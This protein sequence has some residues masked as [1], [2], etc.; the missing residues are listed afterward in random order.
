MDNRPEQ[1]KPDI[2]GEGSHSTNIEKAA[3]RQLASPACILLSGLPG[4]GKRRCFIAD[5]IRECD[6]AQ[7]NVL[8]FDPASRI[9][10]TPS[11]RDRDIFV[12][13][14][15]NANTIGDVIDWQERQRKHTAIPFLLILLCMDDAADFVTNVAL[16]TQLERARALGATVLISTRT[17]ASR[18]L[19]TLAKSTKYPNVGSMFTHVAQSVFP[20]SDHRC[21]VVHAAQDPCKL[22]DGHHVVVLTPPT[23]AESTS[24]CAASAS[25]SSSSVVP[26][27]AAIAFSHISPH[28]C[29]HVPSSIEV[30]AAAID[31]VAQP[32][33]PHPSAP[34]EWE[35]FMTTE[36]PTPMP[37]KKKTTKGEPELPPTTWNCKLGTQSACGTIHIIMATFPTYNDYRAHDNLLYAGCRAQI[38]QWLDR[39]FSGEQLGDMESIGT[40]DWEK[41]HAQFPENILHFP[42][43]QEVAKIYGVVVFWDGKGDNGDVQNY[44]DKS[45]HSVDEANAH[46]QS[47]AEEDMEECNENLKADEPHSCVLEVDPRN[48]TCDGKMFTVCRIGEE[49]RYKDPKEIEEGRRNLY[50]VIAIP[51]PV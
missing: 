10:E 22:V 19:A 18:F 20:C 27:S 12:Q 14:S 35:A 24:A 4:S 31:A 41:A 34:T 46:A 40:A 47:L 1:S 50:Y 39:H 17:P 15:I 29:C 48:M 8:I 36:V 7:N 32:C 21:F 43:H 13:P 42:A 51:L 38:Q 6:F 45:F 37:K 28:Y 33:S 11:Y 3:I 5:V 9:T 25:S 49:E 2:I 23:P 44:V 26:S 30:V 16:R